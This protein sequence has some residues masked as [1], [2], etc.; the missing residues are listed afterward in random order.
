MTSLHAAISTFLGLE[1]RTL[2]LTTTRTPYP[3][4]RASLEVG[5][6]QLV[7]ELC[8]D[9]SDGRFWFVDHGVAVTHRTPVDDG[10]PRHDAQRALL[11]GVERG[12]RRRSEAGAAA[13]GVI[14]AALA[15]LT[16]DA[17]PSREAVTESPVEPALRAA[18]GVIHGGTSEVEREIVWA[19]FE[20][21]L[22]T[23]LER[24]GRSGAGELARALALDPHGALLLL[25]ALVPLGL[26]ETT[27]ER[28]FALR[29]GLSRHLADL[30]ELVARRREDALWWRQLASWVRSGRTA[31]SYED[32][33]TRSE[34]SWQR[35]IGT[36][37]L[38]L[39]VQG[40]LYS[41]AELEAL[42]LTA[43]RSL[44]DV[45]IASGH[46][47]VA[48]LRALPGLRLIGVDYPSAI[49]IA[50]RTLEQAGLAARAELIAGA[51]YDEDWQ[52]PKGFDVAWLRGTL[53]VE[54]PESNQRLFAKLR[55]ALPA[56]GALLIDERLANVNEL[57][58]G[59]CDLYWSL[60]TR[61][62]R[63]YDL[64]TVVELL[65]SSGFR[66]IDVLWRDAPT[67]CVRAR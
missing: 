42:E 27:D 57:D 16:P 47:A 18:R 4:V 36:I 46:V 19:A 14:A 1:G 5:G 60:G 25:R 32:T 49:P 7:F 65:K 66:R 6:E 64:P 67:T 20:V 52:P 24:R 2:E 56:E 50:R 48:F 40:T 23:E 13:A 53:H 38:G 15:G 43:T 34:E 58:S 9:R 39:E 61:R 21:G 45:G 41:A 44:L 8:E 11:Q 51:F 33:V 31:A 3:C 63:A 12:A 37:A 55:R 17:A 59:W 26:V 29:T 54:S 28:R 10:V 35:Y 22:L 30:R 62:G